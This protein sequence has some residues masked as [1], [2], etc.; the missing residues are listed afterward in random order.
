MGC[1]CNKRLERART[2]AQAHQK[3]QARKLLLH[4]YHGLGDA[5]LFR[6]AL[7]AIKQQR[8][9]W[10]VDVITTYGKDTLLKDVCRNVFLNPDHALKDY[11]EQKKLRWL[12]GKPC[13]KFYV[14][15][16]PA[17]FLQEDIGL[18]PILPSCPIPIP[19][20][21]P[22]H[23]FATELDKPF[24]VIHYKGNSCR[25]FKDL[26]DEQAQDIINTLASN[27]KREVI[28][29]DWDQRCKV[30]NCI[31]PTELWGSKDTGDGLTIA[32]LISRADLFVGIDSGPSYIATLTDTPSFIIYTGH[33]PIHYAPNKETAPNTTVFVPRNI[34]Q[35]GKGNKP[36]CHR[37]FTA[38][39]NFW[40]YGDDLTVVL[41]KI[42]Q[43]LND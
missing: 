18:D 42:D 26:S 31:V 41:N 43:T 14:A 7:A 16:K 28:L 27:G 24:C 4:F 35:M 37:Y 30:R 22:A 34:N 9:N 39:Y 40:N 19:Q 12:E 33:H 15:N 3:K 25:G 36:L 32:T 17:R 8:P 21:N 6:Y 11:D 38:N 13:N 20:D 23:N 1:G 29:L 5:A 2:Q 10:E